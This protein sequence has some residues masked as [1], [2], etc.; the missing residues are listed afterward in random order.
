MN[1]GISDE[2][3]SDLEAIATSTTTSFVELVKLSGLDP[4][5]DFVGAD[6]RG[7]DLREQDLTKFNLTGA[8]ITGALTSGAK[9]DP[10]KSPSVAEPQVGDESPNVDDSWR[11]SN[12]IEKS[13]DIPDD[14]LKLMGE[15][16]SEGEQ[17]HSINFEKLVMLST[18]YKR[19]ISLIDRFFRRTKNAIAAPFWLRDFLLERYSVYPRRFLKELIQHLADIELIQEFSEREKLMKSIVWN[20]SDYSRGKDTEKL[21]KMSAGDDEI[22]DFLTDLA[23]NDRSFEVRRRAIENLVP[24]EQRL[25]HYKNLAMDILENDADDRVQGA[26]VSALRYLR[27]VD[28]EVWVLMF[29]LAAD[30]DTAWARSEA[31][32]SLELEVGTNDEIDAIIVQLLHKSIMGPADQGMLAAISVLGRLMKQNEASGEYLLQRFKENEDELARFWLFAVLTRHFRG[33]HFVRQAIQCDLKNNRSYIC[34]EEVVKH[35]VS[36]DDLREEYLSRLAENEAMHSFDQVRRVAQMGVANSS[37]EPQRKVAFLV[38]RFK[39]DTSGTNRQ[40][41]ANKLAADFPSLNETKDFFETLDEKELEDIRF[42]DNAQNFLK[43][44][45]PA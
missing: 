37:W 3:R 35:I 7:A 40:M 44:M 8:N 43:K 26:A 32:L 5:K 4:T 20:G 19:K 27:K 45:V 25:E 33:S 24:N 11:E 17:A 42:A 28:T 1:N 2:L 22:Y 9:F 18:G 21:A 23:I 13:A 38:E 29:D 12:H 10:E 6:L 34:R 30:L 15:I 16:R 39:D 41:L 36:D 14:C 31:I